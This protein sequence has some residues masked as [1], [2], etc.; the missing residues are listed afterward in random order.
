MT[1]N[2]TTG[3]VILLEVLLV[4]AVSS[5]ISNQMIERLG[6]VGM[7]AVLLYAIYDY[8]YG[9]LKNIVFPSKWFN[10]SYWPFFLLIIL[11]SA[12]IGYS[13][14]LSTAYSYSRYAIL[15]FLV[16]YFLFQRQ[17]HEKTII[18]G[19]IAGTGFVCINALCQ[20]SSLPL[21][22]RISSSFFD[23]PNFLCMF[24]IPSVPF[25]AA[26]TL[27]KKEH[28]HWKLITLVMTI[29]I[30]FVIAITGSR[31]GIMGICLGGV[32]FLLVQTIFVRKLMIKELL[33]NYTM[34]ALIIACIGGT[35]FFTFHNRVNQHQQI[36]VTR[37]YDNQR[38][39]FWKSSYHMWQDHKVLGVGLEHWEQEY[40][41]YY[42][43]P[44]ATEKNIEQPHNMFCYFFASTGMVGGIGFLFFTFGMFFYLCYKL[45]QNPN[46]IFLNAL[47]WSFLAIMFHGMVDR[48]IMQR[49][50]MILYNAYL[51]IGLASVAYQERIDN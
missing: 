20:F 44:K 10:L 46:N 34:V 29:L 7:W 6:R 19:I 43:L 18:V 14:S 32:I 31:G 17:F 28:L 3:F 49:Q 21:G 26:Y 38:I 1:K 15:T 9:K 4:Y 2:I 51:G 12:L 24:L 41:S 45:K 11:S 47:V 25:L 23:S 48:G 39:L 13:D 40:Y 5:A 50:L 30:S 8:R 27:K 22:T 37:S 35:Y 42:I 33:M 36:G 16:F